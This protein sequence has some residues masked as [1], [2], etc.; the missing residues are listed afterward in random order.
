ME[1][2]AMNNLV[3]LDVREGVAT[4]TLND[5]ARLNPLSAPLVA[6]VLDALEAVRANPQARVLVLRGEGRAFCAGANLQDFPVPGAEA[7]GERPAAEI[8]DELMA[9]ANPMALALRDLPVPVLC[10]VHGATAGGG[11]GLALAADIV[12]AARSA[13]FYLPFVPALALVPDLGAAWS[14]LR[15]IGP[16][17]TAA[18]TLLGDRLGAEQAAHWGLIWACV[19]DASLEQETARL[20][21][22]L[23]ALPAGAI[24]ET[25]ALLREAGRR[26]LAAQLE[27]ERGRQAALM[28]E[29]D[30]GEGLKAFRDKRKPSFGR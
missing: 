2:K 26:E 8:V 6:G 4:L 25:R 30:F 5:P 29:A 15:A 7:P 24:R 28:R 10:A 27:Y 23:C 13:Y 14:M 16:A 20:A 3:R 12:V 21:A 9:A 19:D 22:R 1:A 18:L 17:R 11:V